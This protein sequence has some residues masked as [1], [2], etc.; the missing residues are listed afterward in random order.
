[1]SKESPKVTKIQKGRETIY[2]NSNFASNTMALN[3]Y[4]SIITLNV[5]G[6]NVP[7]KRQWDRLV[8]GIKEGTHCM[9]HWVL[10][11]SDDSWNFT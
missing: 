8:V 4:L 7:N 1:M 5:S 11:A 6:L 3:S 2:R 9:V 10:Y